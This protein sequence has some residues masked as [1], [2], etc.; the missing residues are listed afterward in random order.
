MG[1]L[2]SVSGD[3]DLVRNV[4]AIEDALL[5]IA[6]T[7]LTA[8]AEIT[9]RLMRALCPSLTGQ[10]KDSI[11]FELRRGGGPKTSVRK[12]GSLGKTRVVGDITAG[13]QSTLVGSSGRKGG[14][15]QWQLARLQEFGTTKMPA[16]PF[17]YPA[18]RATKK[19]VRA[20]VAADLRK[21]FKAAK[22]TTARA[23]A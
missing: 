14:G 1:V 3:A 8:N 23:A 13:D 11:K 12:N 20:A 9:L 17:F 19:K 21:A 4:A 7:T 5:S 16:H 10:L 15:R 6:P 18:W 2:W 22:I